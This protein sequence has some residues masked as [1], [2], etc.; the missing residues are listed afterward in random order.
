MIPLFGGADA[1]SKFLSKGSPIV[2]FGAGQV[3]GVGN[4]RYCGRDKGLGVAPAMLEKSLDTEASL[5]PWRKR[6]K[7]Q[8]SPL[9][10]VQ[11]NIQSSHYF[12]RFGY[13]ETRIS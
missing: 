8:I 1:F 4:G 10:W 2:R 13:K 9:I 11:K 6:R 12:V 7:M 3:F 5:N